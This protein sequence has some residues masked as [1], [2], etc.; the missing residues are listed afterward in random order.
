MNAIKRLKYSDMQSG[1]HDPDGVRMR[2][3]LACWKEQ[4]MNFKNIERSD[5]FTGYDGNFV[6]KEETRRKLTPSILNFYKEAKRIGW[7]SAFDLEYG[8]RFK[9][10]DDIDQFNA[11][12]PMGYEILK[13]GLGDVSP[14][15]HEYYIYNRS[16]TSK[17]GSVFRG[18]DFD[19]MMNLGGEGEGVIYNVI[20]NERSADGEYQVLFYSP[21]GLAIRFKSFAHLLVN[22]YLEEHQRSK[23]LDASMGHIFYF[24]GDWK[25]TC[26]PLLFDMDE[27]ESWGQRVPED[28]YREPFSS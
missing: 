18:R 27:I 20:T 6:D 3:F 15:D 9:N 16:Q 10:I 12:E 7:F 5:E 17:S 11:V 2:N 21:H 13:S 24:K 28:N 25:D 4:T 1:Y 8:N 26:V 22:L 19:S 23:G 14:P